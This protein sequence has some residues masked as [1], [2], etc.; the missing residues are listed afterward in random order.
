MSSYVQGRK[1]THRL[2]QPLTQVLQIALLEW[3]VCNMAVRTQ[4][5]QGEAGVLEDSLSECHG[6]LSPPQV[7]FSSQ[8]FSRMWKTTCS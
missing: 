3:D 8:L 1:A 6:P 7:S 5:E 2:W 4:P